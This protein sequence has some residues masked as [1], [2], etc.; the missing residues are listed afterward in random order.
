MTE[1]RS[2]SREGVAPFVWVVIGVPV[3]LFLPL[4]IAAGE[5]FVLGSDHFEQFLIRVGVHEI[6]G[7][8]YQPILSFF[9]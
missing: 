5:H 1:E 7:R 2:E 3:L 6:L 8:L 9:Q 4:G